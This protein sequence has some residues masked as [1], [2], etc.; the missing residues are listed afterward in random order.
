MLSPLRSA[1]LAT[2]IAVGSV[3]VLS[4][5]TVS[6]GS[7]AVNGSA[8]DSIDSAAAQAYVLSSM[9]DRAAAQD[10]EYIE[11]TLDDL[12]PGHEFA[13]DG[14]AAD[15]LA[16]G[17]VFGTVT[18][19]AP[20]AGYVISGDD[21]AEGTAVDFDDPDSI[22]RVLVLTVTSD[23]RVGDVDSRKIKVGVVID[24]GADVPMATEGYLSLG[25]IMLVLNEPGKYSFDPSLYSIRQSGALL[26]LVSKSGSISF[27]AMGTEGTAFL[28]GTDT[29]KE[30]VSDSAIA[31]K[32][33]DESDVVEVT[34]DDG[35]F[36][37]DDE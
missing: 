22:W 17:I 19:V 13:I 4:G 31:E 9:V 6:T 28:D 30:V 18:D 27:P 35:E 20:G 14:A 32:T 37:R 10:G 23:T 7:T 11:D 2:A 26:G 24:G 5:C 8:V 33:A 21:A 16:E 36:Q 12:L 25:R 29:V 15:T 3:A 1:V 34:F